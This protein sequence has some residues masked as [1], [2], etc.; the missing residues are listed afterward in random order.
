MAPPCSVANG[1]S[2]L[3]R[4]QALHTT[5]P[6][7]SATKTISDEGSAARR[8]FSITGSQA[9]SSPQTCASMRAI[10]AKSSS[11]VTSRRLT[12]AGSLGS[13][14]ISATGATTTVS[15]SSATKPAVR[16]RSARSAGRSCPWSFHSKD[17]PRSAKTR[18]WRAISSSSSVP[19][20][21]PRSRYSTNPRSGQPTVRT[22]GPSRSACTFGGRP[23][24]MRPR[25]SSSAVRRAAASI[26]KRAALPPQR[27]APRRALTAGCCRAAAWAARRAWSAPSRARRSAPDACARGGSRRPR[28][29]ARRP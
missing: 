20:R 9:N 23:S 27:A 17:S 21:P 28:S 26:T 19:S 16:S 6:A 11:P 13:R 18:T 8:S 7:A 1:A 12:P 14:A 4:I 24:G 29:R 5:S 22:S 15:C 10:R 2:R 25:S 3:N